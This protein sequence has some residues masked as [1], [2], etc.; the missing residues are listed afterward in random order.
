MKP[1][2]LISSD[3][4]N[5][6]SHS[7]ATGVVLQLILHVLSHVIVESSSVLAV[8]IV[9]D[10]LLVCTIVNC[11]DLYLFMLH[12][13]MHTLYAVGSKRLSDS[14]RSAL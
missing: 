1:R 5:T 14:S 7:I 3:V 2:D 4:A 13:F 12:S 11:L 9:N 8:V 6:Y 10:V